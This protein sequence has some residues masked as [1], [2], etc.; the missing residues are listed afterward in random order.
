MNKLEP[1]IIYICT[2][3]GAEELITCPG[4]QWQAHQDKCVWKSISDECLN[5]RI[6]K[7]T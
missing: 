1:K 6:N 7:N 4:Y 2:L 5:K 3:N